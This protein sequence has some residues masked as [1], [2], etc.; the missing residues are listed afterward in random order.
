MMSVFAI[1]HDQARRQNYEVVAYLAGEKPY[2]ELLDER[3]RLADYRRWYGGISRDEVEFMG[4][5]V[6]FDSRMPR[7]AV[8]TILGY[9]MEH[10]RLEQGQAMVADPIAGGLRWKG[11]SGNQYRLDITFENDGSSVFAVGSIHTEPEGPAH[12]RAIVLPVRGTIDDVGKKAIEDAIIYLVATCV[13]SELQ[14]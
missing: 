7:D 10:H 9:H 6:Y 13:N 14:R 2:R 11:D 5:P 4:K 3:A 1:A 12:L 8:R